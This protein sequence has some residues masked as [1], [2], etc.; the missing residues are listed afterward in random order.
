VKTVFIGRFQPFHRGHHQVVEKY[1]EEHEL[2][3]AIGSSE[4]EETEKNPLSFK[5]R[6]KLIR[7][8]H[9]DIEITG[10]ADE[11]ESEDGNQ[12]WIQKVKEKTGAEAVI[13]QNPLVK[14]IVARDTELKLIKQDLYQEEIYSGTEVRRRVRSGE[15]WRYLLPDCCEKQFEKL[16]DK[17]KESGIQYNFEPGWKKEN[18]FHDTLD[19]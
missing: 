5:E 10:I 13:S 3:I 2:Q 19:K 1:S 18:S 6:K 16:K 7:A 12:K 4:E 11:D 15:E 8:C 14:D 17:I 9:S